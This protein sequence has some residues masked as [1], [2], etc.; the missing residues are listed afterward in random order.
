MQTRW[1]SGD[2]REGDFDG[3]GG[4]A[5]DQAEDEERFRRHRNVKE[6]FTTESAENTEEK[7]EARGKR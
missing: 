6:D 1:R 2:A 3:V 4:G 5:G 7:M